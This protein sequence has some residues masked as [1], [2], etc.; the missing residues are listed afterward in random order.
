VLVHAALSAAGYL[1]A[2]QPGYSL[3]PGGRSRVQ[4]VPL[5]GV[6]ATGR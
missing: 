5:S 1:L 4:T 3:L 2:W 6:E